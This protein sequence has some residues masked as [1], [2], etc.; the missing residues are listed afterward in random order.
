[1]GKII[2]FTGL[3]GSGK[4]TIAKKLA[5][6][7]EV[8]GKKVKVLDGD[9]IR[10]TSHKHLGFSPKDIHE[11]N[12]LIAKM[13]K[14][15]SE[16]VDFVLVPIISPYRSDRTLVRKTIG[17]DFFEVFVNAPLKECIKRDV[18]GLYKKALK[19]EIKNFIGLSDSNPYEPPQFPD[20]EIKTMNCS[21][22]GGVQKIINFLK[23][24]QLVI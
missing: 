14:K 15:V 12:F 11:N 10:A 16:N 24:L 13:A 8:F 23:T 21:P 17:P 18:K 3:S 9:E 19:G 6:R 5:E 1:M 7:L 20:V 2:W 22:D 4:S